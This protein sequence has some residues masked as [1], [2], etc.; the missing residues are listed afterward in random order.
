M[1]ELQLSTIQRYSTKDGP[2]I[3]STVFLIGCNLR[4]VWC[5]NP[6][7]M[8]PEQKLLHF[9]SL[10]RGCGSCVHAYPKAVYQMQ[11]MIHLYP[12]A[13]TYKEALRDVCP[14][15]AYEITGEW[16][17]ASVLAKRLLKDQAFYE[18][19]GGGVT[20]SGGEALLQA[21]AVYETARLLKAENVSVCIDTAGDVPWSTLYSM[22]DV[23]DLFLY[24]IKAFDSHLHRRLTGV[25]NARILENAR[26][27]AKHHVPMWIRMVIVKGYNDDREDLRQRLQ[28]IASLQDAV[29]RVDLLPYHAL[30][31]GK[32]QS[33]GLPYPIETDATPDEETLRFCLDE[34]R[35][36]GLHVHL[37]TL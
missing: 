37:H 21:E 22:C 32:Y 30:G 10:C 20:F 19:S 1:V 27:L 5:S 35:R 24:D 23:C 3:R 29:K 14:Y 16:M 18:Q 26:L 13:A 36:L 12:C 7:L 34:A 8:L 31:K 6:E 11:G 33:M 2:G 9:S 17:E 15:D 25:G 4:C 28:F